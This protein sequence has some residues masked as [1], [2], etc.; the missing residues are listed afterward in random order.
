M[1]AVRQI[2]A[3]RQVNKALA[4]RNGPDTSATAALPLQSNVRVWQEQAGWQGPFI[5]FTNNRT[6]YTIKL[7]QGPRDFRITAVKPW[8]DDKLKGQIE[9]MTIDQAEEPQKG[10]QEA[11]VVANDEPS[12][13]RRPGRPQK[14]PAGRPQDAFIAGTAS[15]VFMLSDA[16]ATVKED[17]DYALAVEL[18]KKG[19]IKM[20]GKP[21][22]E[23]DH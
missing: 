22:E 13:R 16:F 8:H 21:F 10:A 7:P 18:R 11:I 15:D 2:H 6:T 9:P 3:K 1:E 4:T 19:I 12:P 17:A 14:E 23:S 20:P 5:L